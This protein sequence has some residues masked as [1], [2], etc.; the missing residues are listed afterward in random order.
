MKHDELVQWEDPRIGPD[1]IRQIAASIDT[2]KTMMALKFV[3]NGNVLVDFIFFHF[4]FYRSL[5]GRKDVQLLLGFIG[6]TRLDTV[7]I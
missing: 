3:R 4:V 2:D 5:I 1:V 6:T 7:Q